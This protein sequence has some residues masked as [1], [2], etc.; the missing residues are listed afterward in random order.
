MIELFFWLQPLMVMKSQL[1]EIAG[2]VSQDLLQE[3]DV[4]LM[5]TIDV[6]FFLCVCVCLKILPFIFGGC[7]RQTKTLQYVLHEQYSNYLKIPWWLKTQ[8]HE[9]VGGEIQF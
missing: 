9:V 4:I 8:D 3:F 2:Y 1:V 7:R 6:F 5:L